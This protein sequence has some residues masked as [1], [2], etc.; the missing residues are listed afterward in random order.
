[1]H[2]DAAV[3]AER[4]RDSF[5]R[6]GLM[7]P[8]GAQMV[9]IESGAV[10][11]RL[12]FASQLTQQHGFCHAGATSAI[13]DTAGGYAGLSVFP[14]DS[15]VL[16]VEFKITLVAPAKGEALEA[17]GSVVRSGKTLTVCD[18][19]IYALDGGAR[20]LVA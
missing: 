6:Q 11:L 8:L 16:T 20:V 10:R 1:G 14:P 5:S 9:Q 7:R 12:P 19:K 2:A 18:L 15:T 17:V 13:A 4:I 3:I